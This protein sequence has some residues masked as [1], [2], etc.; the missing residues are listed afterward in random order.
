MDYT[1]G[2]FANGFIINMMPRWL[3]DVLGYA[4]VYP[5]QRHLKKAVR[6]VRPVIEERLAMI[7]NKKPGVSSEESEPV[8][9][10]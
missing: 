9:D 4:I 10:A 7:Q 1:V 8:S 3:R 5:N 2:V 6:I